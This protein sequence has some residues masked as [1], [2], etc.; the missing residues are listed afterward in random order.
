MLHINETSCRYKL[1]LPLGYTFY[2]NICI[3]M[4]TLD[5]ILFSIISILQLHKQWI[6]SI[7]N[8]VNIDSYSMVFAILPFIIILILIFFFSL[9]LY[10]SLGGWNFFSF[11]CLYIGC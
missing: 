9:L 6:L 5:Q 3:L 11:L 7:I 4:F 1:L 2:G 10:F 8:D